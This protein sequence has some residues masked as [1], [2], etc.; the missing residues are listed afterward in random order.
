MRKFNKN[1]K[2]REFGDRDVNKT[3]FKA[4]CANCGKDCE[5]PFKPN[6]TKPVLCNDCFRRDNGN[7]SHNDYHRNDGRQTP[8]Q[9]THSYPRPQYS[10]TPDYKRQFEELNAKLDKILKI[11]SP[12]KKEKTQEKAEE[13]IQT[14]Q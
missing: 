4:V 8:Y 6:G 14:E 13:K 1:F 9:R 12:I 10:Q 3:M 7:N 5:V 2:K 11:V